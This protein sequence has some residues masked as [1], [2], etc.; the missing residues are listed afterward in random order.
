MSRAKWKG[1]YLTRSLIILK[2][3]KNIQKGK[4]IFKEINIYSRKSII[5]SNLLKKRL[6]IHNGKNFKIIT[7]NKEMKTF[8]LGEFSFTRKKPKHKP[9]K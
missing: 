7:L 6:K 2:K 1:F 3:Y 4:Y 9:K 5:L 8:K